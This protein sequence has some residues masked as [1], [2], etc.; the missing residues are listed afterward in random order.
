MVG[1]NRDL[2]FLGGE[3]TSDR[4]L[5]KAFVKSISTAACFLFFGF[6]V[7]TGDPFSFT[8]SSEP[9]NLIMYHIPK[10]LVLAKG[11]QINETAYSPA[12][13]PWKLTFSLPI[14]PVIRTCPGI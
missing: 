3:K 8:T 5:S 2:G 6:L 10:E 4:S 7:V 12:T 14:L 11:A 1:N 9:E 13:N